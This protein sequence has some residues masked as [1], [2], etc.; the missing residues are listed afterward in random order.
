[1]PRPQVR[2][3]IQAASHLDDDQPGVRV[4][5]WFPPSLGFSHARTATAKAQAACDREGPNRSASEITWQP[6]NRGDASA[7]ARPRNSP[8]P[9]RIS[10]RGNPVI[11][12]VTAVT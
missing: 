11:R 1:E 9:D 3:V 6:V 4:H 8:L 10:V 7:T 12:E 2:Q 5:R